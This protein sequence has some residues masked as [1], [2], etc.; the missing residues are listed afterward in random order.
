MKGKLYSIAEIKKIFR[1]EKPRFVS[2]RDSNGMYVC[3]W[4]SPTVKLDAKFKEII[5][6][7]N[8]STLD[9]GIYYY[10]QKNAHTKTKDTTEQVFPI[11]VGNVQEL[12]EAPA[13]A[14][15]PEVWTQKQALEI[16]DEKNR[17]FYELQTANK[18][19]QE[20]E[21]QLQEYET[22]TEE[23]SEEEPDQASSWIDGLNKIV[24]TLAPSIDKHFELQ[25]K[26]L[27]ILEMKFNRPEL[28]EKSGR[29]L[30]MDPQYADY[31]DQLIRSNDLESIT[32][33]L[34][35]LRDKYPETFKKVVDQYQITFQ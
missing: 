20:L 8:K 22:E 15:L 10:I 33:E 24:K 23:L 1:E 30:P 5:D 35:F 17:L 16:L 7:L 26:K 34:T 3:T 9:P 18:R 29:I 6:T 27:K 4:N 12:K 13:P 11:A 28:Q 14:P 32:S 21:S 25:E 31:L 2:L 19:I